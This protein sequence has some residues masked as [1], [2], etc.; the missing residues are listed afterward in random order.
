MARKSQDG[1]SDSRVFMVLVA[2]IAVHEVGYGESLSYS[3]SCRIDAA[4]QIN[5]QR[6]SIQTREKELNELK[7]EFSNAAAVIMKEDNSK[8]NENKTT[9]KNN[10]IDKILEAGP[11]VKGSYVEKVLTEKKLILKPTPNKTR[12]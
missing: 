12:L 10:I 2:E 7:Q 6:T 8:E 1:E 11:E 9:R 5:E 3:M 4:F